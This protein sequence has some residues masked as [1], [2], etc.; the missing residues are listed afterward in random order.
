MLYRLIKV[1]VGIGIRLYYRE[2]RVKN[3]KNIPLDEPLIIIANHPNT[4]MDAWMI[5]H[6]CPRPIHFMAKGTLFNSKFKLKLL[7]SLNMIPINRVGEGK[8]DGVSNQNSFQACYDILEAGKTLVIFPE[9]S[10]YQERHLRDLK[11][12]TARIALEAVKRKEGQL[13]VKILPMG[14]NYTQAEK[15]RSR[16]LV[17]IGEP[18]STKDYL[19]DYIENSGKGARKMTEQFRVRLEQLLVNSNTKEEQDLIDQVANIL[20]SRYTK[21]GSENAISEIDLLKRIRNRMDD[22]KV[23]EAWK[24]EEV[25]KLVE[26]VKW[27]NEKLN[28]QTDFLDRRFRSTMFFRQLFFSIIFVLIAVPYFIFGM[29]HNAIQFYLIDFL[30]PKLTKDIEYYAPLAVLLG[31]VLYPLFFGLFAHFIG[32]AFDLS[33]WQKVIYFV[34]MPLGGLFAYFFH[35]YLRHIGYKWKYI[36]LMIRQKEVVLS[37]KAKR[38]RLREYFEI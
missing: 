24:T 1:L 11:S 19:A 29:I 38:D 14:L 33:F 8:T 22:F 4:L 21:K 32:N 17:D 20:Q 13:D 31:L 12:G 10:S 26:T 7:S 3:R 35:R 34:M 5:G 37:L 25:R 27:E 2:I 30:I 18:M 9:G 36:F 15:F 16:V 6:I 23:T 28:I